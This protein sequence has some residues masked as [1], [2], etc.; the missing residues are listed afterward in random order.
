MIL[1]LQIFDARV[2]NIILLVDIISLIGEVFY[3]S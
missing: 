1:N 2:S 3:E